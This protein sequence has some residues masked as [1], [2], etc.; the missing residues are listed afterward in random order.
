M[1]AE[2]AKLTSLMA[3]LTQIGAKLDRRNGK[4]AWW[5]SPFR[6][7]RT[8]S[9]KVWLNKN[10]WYDHGAGIGGN[11][12]D[13]IMRYHKCNF[14][15]AL[16]IINERY[17][18]FSFHQQNTSLQESLN[19]SSIADE[20][21][22]YEI[23]S[24]RNIMNGALLHYMKNVRQLNT[25]MVRK[26]C[27]E[28]HYQLNNGKKYFGVGFKNDLD[29]YVVR[30]KYV[31]LNLGSQSGT[32]IKNGSSALLIFEGFIDFLSFISLYPHKEKDFDFIILNSVTSVKNLLQNR[33]EELLKYKSIWLALDNDDTGEKH[34][35]KLLSAFPITALDF[36]NHY[37]DF[38]D[39]NDFLIAVKK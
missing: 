38:K 36:R 11:V 6:N 30:N 19:K 35:E 37:A 20:R 39:L 34:T 16:N 18:P 17:A 21:K 25:N 22:K 7:E 5:L 14:K 9:F 28:V 13:F 12:L 33:K 27:R 31:K 15:E 24:V 8:A 26:Y 32:T 2:T 29:G 4:E 10:T 1:N 3:I 23:T